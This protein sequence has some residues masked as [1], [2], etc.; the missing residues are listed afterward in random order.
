V[1]RPRA[2][3]DRLVRF[4]GALLLVA[5]ILMDCRRL[6][7]SALW[8]TSDW[9]WAVLTGILVALIG[10]VM[11]VVAIRRRRSRR[12][13]ERGTPVLGMTYTVAMT[14]GFFATH[15]KFAPQPRVDSPFMV[16]ALT[17]QILLAVFLALLLVSLLATRGRRVRAVD[18]TPPSEN[19]FRP[20]TDE[21]I[22]RKRALSSRRRRRNR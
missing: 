21:G 11:A 16:G 12:G 4:A 1:T 14:L 20:G 7:A 10:V 17:A 8:D 15:R 6:H 3:R 18:R 22:R 9:L 19:S 13:P 2:I 5:V